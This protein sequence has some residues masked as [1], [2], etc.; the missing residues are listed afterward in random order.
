M[1]AIHGVVLALIGAFAPAALAQVPSVVER[2]EPAQEAY[3]L[4]SLAA[5]DP[6]ALERVFRGSSPAEH[7]RA[8]VRGKVVHVDAWALSGPL[9]VLMNA[10]W[11]GKDFTPQ[12][13]RL[14]DFQGTPRLVEATLKNIVLGHKQFKG[15]VYRD[16]S[17]LDGRPA[18]VID[19]RNTA[20]SI[21]YIRDEF[22]YVGNG[23]WLG[24]TF[25]GTNGKE[26]K[27]FML[28]FAIDAK[29]EAPL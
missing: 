10:L 8:R 19:Y 11:S 29:P 9:S 3:T 12:S 26:G 13:P 16:G 20:P 24:W 22:R 17:W 27:R 18:W 23:V 25:D 15:E 14:R 4:D 6:Q 28:S 1:S 21:G 2:A 5:M 7:P